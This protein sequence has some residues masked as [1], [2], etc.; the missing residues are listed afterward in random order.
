MDIFDG[1][2]SF[3][4]KSKEWGIKDKSYERD[5][6]LDT[7][8]FIN[9]NPEINRTSILINHIE[10][11]EN[12]TLLNTILDNVTVPPEIWPIS[13]TVLISMSNKENN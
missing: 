5:K 7:I 9:E 1:I 10:K 6:K 8:N 3:T 11:G 13:A 4:L 12:E 2:L